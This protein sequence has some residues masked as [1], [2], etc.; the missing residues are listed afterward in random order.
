MVY[1]S[2]W[3]LRHGV[4]RFC[5]WGPTQ[6]NSPI[7]FFAPDGGG[8][9]LSSSVEAG[10]VIQAI[11]VNFFRRTRAQPARV[12]RALA[13]DSRRGFWALADQGIVSIGNFGVN[14]ALAR[15]FAANH[16]LGQYGAF[17]VL[18]ELMFFL[19]GIQ[20]ALLH[21]PL[22]VR[23]A[24]ADRNVLERMA[25]Q[26]LTLTLLASPLLVLGMI[27]TA[28]V[29]QISLTAGLWAG[30]ALVCWQLQETTRRSLMAHLRFGAACVGDAVSYGGQFAIVV[31]LVHT[32]RLDLPLTFQA[33]AATSALACAVQVIQLGLLSRPHSGVWRFARESWRIGRWVMFANLANLFSGT[34]FNWNIAYWAGMETLG[35]YHALYNLIRP[36]HPLAFAMGTLITPSVAKVQQTQGLHRAKIT[37]ARFTLLGAMLL[38]PYLAMLLFFPRFALAGFYG[39]DSR[40]IQYASLIQVSAIAVAFVYASTAISAFLNGIERV[41][42]SFIGQLTYAA[43]FLFIALPMTA[44]MGLMGAIWAWLAA[45]LLRFVVY[46]YYFVTDSTIA[47][48]AE[49]RELEGQHVSA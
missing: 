47:L 11:A 16:D 9:R 8:A 45:S 30:V 10:Q 1:S 26:S 17:W 22:T 40:Y 27:A 37:A 14:V 12:A 25:S 42:Q 35:V 36:A 6:Y 41:R 21:F 48:P 7:A 28:W 24:A 29:A 49:H 23:A 18:M 13:E 2:H 15:Y 38:C 5:R 20:A 19:N 31:L 3:F 34:F 44:I 33:I 46:G 39:W 43:G 4:S 32:G